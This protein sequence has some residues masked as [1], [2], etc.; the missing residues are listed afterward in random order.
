MSFCVRVLVCFILFFA[1]HSVRGVEQPSRLGE[2][3]AFWS[4]VSRSVREGDFA[5]YAATCHQEGVLVS[6]A[7]QSSYPLS[8]A[9]A[10]WKQGFEDT[11]AG[12]MNADVQFRFTQRIGDDSTSHETGIFRYATI[13]ANGK[14]TPAYIHFAALLVKRKGRWLVMMEHQKTPATQEEWEAAKSGV[15]PNT[16][17][18]TK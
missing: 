9:L 17:P 11:K 4:E 7:K 2:L 10:G 3:D 18:A 12:K 5:G 15:K 14:E 1:S 6:E 16:K 8:K 13:D